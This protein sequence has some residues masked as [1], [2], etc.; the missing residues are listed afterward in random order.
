MAGDRNV[1]MLEAKL[2]TKI[3]DAWIRRLKFEFRQ[4]NPGCRPKKGPTA[5]L[6]GASHPSAMTLRLYV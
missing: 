6:S 1:W 2:E 4:H 5:L 3:F